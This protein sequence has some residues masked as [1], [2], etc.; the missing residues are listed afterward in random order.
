LE[1]CIGRYLKGDVNVEGAIVRNL[2][3]PLPYRFKK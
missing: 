3:V 2:L 1:R